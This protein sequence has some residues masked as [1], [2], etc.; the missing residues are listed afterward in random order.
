MEIALTPLDFLERA[1]RLFADRVGVFEG[2][3]EFTY[4][5]F[6]RRCDQHAALL[7]HELAIRRGD[8]VA[9]LCGNT[10]EL[11]EA[12]Y[13]VLRAGAVL[14]PINVRL[15]PTEMRHVLDDSRAAVLFRH[16]DQP[17]PQHG[18]REVLVD[19][20]F[21]D[22][23]RR[24]EGVVLPALAIDERD[25]AEIFYTSGSTGLPKGAVLTHR[26]LYLHAVHSALTSQVTG[27]DVILH[28]IPLFHVNGWGVPHYLTMLG[29]QHVMLPRFDTAEVL[30]LIEKHRVTRLNAVPTMMR[31]IL[32]HPNRGDYDL[33]S[34]THVLLGGSPPGAGLMAEVEAAFGC[35]CLCGYGM[36]EA[37]PSLTRSVPKPGTPST[38]DQR[39]STGLPIMGVDVRV[40]EEAGNEVPWD[41]TTVGEICA[42]SN[43]IMREYVHAPEAT[44][45]V[46]V[47]GWLRT[48]DL[49]VVR[50]DGYLRLVDRK[51]DLIISGG[52]NIATPEV[53]AVLA[54]HP[55]VREVSVVGVADE[56]WGEVPRA[57]VV[58]RPDSQ[59]TADELTVFARGRL[60]HFKVP[61]DVVFLDQLPMSGTGK[62]SKV[63]LREWPV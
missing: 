60:A 32:D 36:T 6:G 40:F 46:I 16:P 38:A 9:W 54:M 43:H 61:R 30:R 48:G 15:S 33:S 3:R 12:Y 24:Q 11:L 41:D 31:M 8:V 4:A 18:V 14:L 29:G 49:A 58:L 13:G 22:T 17:D 20:S 7:H 5:E 10:R 19:A 39:A 56:R 26:S 28:T 23:L 27:D 51:K 1:R 57:F 55:A 2:D 63:A 25:P 62:I 35:P 59:L 34:L 44:G 52:E 53:E 37:G 21:D 45:A 47:D 50:P 42:R